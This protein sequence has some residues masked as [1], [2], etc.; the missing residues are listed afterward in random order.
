[1][2][3][4]R[5]IH[6]C[7]VHENPLP[8]GATALDDTM[9]A[10]PECWARFGLTVPG[11]NVALPG[12]HQPPPQLCRHSLE[13]IEHAI[14]GNPERHVR[15]CDLHDRHTVAPSR[16]KSC[17]DKD[18]KPCADFALGDTQDFHLFAA[19]IGDSVV[20]VYAACGL[21]DTGVRVRFHTRHLPWLVG[22]GHPDV[23]FLPHVSTSPYEGAGVNASLNPH[24]ELLAASHARTP[25]RAVWYADSIALQ[26]GR[27]KFAPRRP[28]R[29]DKPPSPLP[30]RDYVV[31][32]PFSHHGSREWPG[33]RWAALADMI[34]GSGKTVV[35]IDGPR[36][37][38]KLEKLFGR[39]VKNVHWQWG[40]KPQDSIAFI[41]NAS[42]FVGNDSGMAHVAGLHGT[43]AV[44]VQTQL[45]S[46]YV[47][48]RV[49]APTVKVIGADGWECQ[50]CAWQRPCP[51]VHTGRC[52]ALDSI[53]PHKVFKA[54]LQLA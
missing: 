13:V 42:A 34:A 40:M 44:V 29:V 15:A 1:M 22:V 50:G 33:D 10:L 6:V 24:G 49:T 7:P 2:T 8:E 54:V 17:R 12:P 26:S 27:P 18:G 48:D 14:C 39:C 16:I 23:E 20:G 38:P 52:G 25:S 53:P 28:E 32:S 5:K 41:A 30:G 47:F 35:V 46:W 37:G 9:C 21:A 11:R 45:P 36:Q 31:L 3:V 43:P 4:T 19:G 51:S